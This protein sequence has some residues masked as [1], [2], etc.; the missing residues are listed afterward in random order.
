MIFLKKLLLIERY[1]K[2][3]EAFLVALGM[4]RLRVVIVLAEIDDIVDSSILSEGGG[5]GGVYDYIVILVS[6]QCFQR[7]KTKYK[8]VEY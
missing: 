5:G 3:S 4:N 2:N 1:H 7:K 6:R 8:R